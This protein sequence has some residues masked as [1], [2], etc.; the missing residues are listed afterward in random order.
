MEMM[1]T[2]GRNLLKGKM[3]LISV[4][5]PVKMFE[6]RS[7]LE[8]LTDVWVHTKYLK[9]AAGTEDPVEQMRL[10]V[11]WFISGMQF[12]FLGF[13]KPFNPILGETWQGISDSGL[14]IYV[15]QISHHPPISAFE[16]DMPDGS[17]VFRG[18]SE[19]TASF[20]GKTVK[21]TAKGKRGV[22][23]RD[24]SC[25]DITYPAYYL[26]GVL[27]GELR[28]ELGGSAMFVNEK[29]GLQ[30]EVKFG[31]Y[32][33]GSTKS[34]ESRSDYFEGEIV[35]IEPEDRTPKL[36]DSMIISNAS[37]SWLSHLNWDGKRYWTL[38]EDEPDHFASLPE[39]ELVLPSDVRYRE[40][41]LLVGRGDLDEAQKAKQK[42]EK[43]QRHDKKLRKANAS[44]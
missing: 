20:S 31:P 34:F 16:A 19:P 3:N 39:G 29:K 24:G 6:P 5:M 18:L 27:Y 1:K 28:G 23:F 38:A 8:K 12:V 14:R 36:G 15:E 2:A 22:Y 21:T 30:C 32:A 10:I 7:Y 37:G 17:F 9:E 42:L 25:I 26:R 13:K 43:L 33:E 4:S 44:E 35:P 41:L 11:A 40:D